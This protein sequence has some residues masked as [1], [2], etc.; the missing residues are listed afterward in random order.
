M[1]FG[2]QIA[3]QICECVKLTE[4]LMRYAISDIHGCLKT[5]K[6]LVEEEL[7]IGAGDQL[8]F[9]GDYLDRGPDVKG[10]L[11]YLFKLDSE[12]I[13]QV[14][15]LGNHEGIFLDVMAGN[16]SLDLW[17]ANGG[18]KTLQSFGL[19]GSYSRT[20]ILARFPQEYLDYIRDMDFYRI[21]DDYI[22]VHAGLEFN[23]NNPL[24]D[25]HAMLWTRDFQP[26]PS[27]T[28]GRNILVGHTPQS[29]SFI[30][31]QKVEGNNQVIRI[32]GGCVY[33]QRKELGR[34]FAF[35]MDT[36]EFTSTPNR[37]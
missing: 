23:R 30:I 8:F 24:K 14:L 21:L 22:L 29:A 13:I 28:K 9:L 10:V 1:C 12:G 4:W 19:S 31:N 37:E 18:D 33:N 27:W 2:M 32:D 35:N 16:A 20:E 6:F 7:K 15:L 5:L 3:C 11:D 36:Y 25:K 34:L 17:L 26:D